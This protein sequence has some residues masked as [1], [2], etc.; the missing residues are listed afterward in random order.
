MF[1]NQPLRN[2]EQSPELLEIDVPVGNQIFIVTGQNEL[3]EALVGVDTN[4]YQINTLVFSTNT[5]DLRRNF[6]RRSS[7]TFSRYR[8]SEIC[9][10]RKSNLVLANWFSTPRTSFPIRPERSHTPLC[11]SV[12]VF[13]QTEFASSCGFHRILEASE[14]NEEAC[15]ALSR[16]LETK[17][18]DFGFGTAGPSS[19]PL[20]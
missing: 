1:Q 9:M 6:C 4:N 15:L 11:T 13:P 5:Q 7:N 17:H 12:L 19:V 20:S 8:L 10:L 3:T 16:F 14:S 18:A 2:V